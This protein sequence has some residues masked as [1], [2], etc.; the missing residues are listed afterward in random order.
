[1]LERDQS[2]IRTL[3]AAWQIQLSNDEVTQEEQEGIGEETGKKNNN[4]EYLTVEKEQ[5]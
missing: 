1:M 3:G 2:E 4:L 5:D